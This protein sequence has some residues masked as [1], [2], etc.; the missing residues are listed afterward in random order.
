MKRISLFLILIPSILN[1]MNAASN[2]TQPDPVEMGITITMDNDN[3]KAHI[4]VRPLKDIG[5]S[6]DLSSVTHDR[7]WVTYDG[8]KLTITQIIPNPNGQTDQLMVLFSLK[9]HQ[10]EPEYSGCAMGKYGTCVPLGN[11]QHD[12]QYVLGF[13]DA[14]NNDSDT[15]LTEDRELDAKS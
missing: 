13:E 15:F 7:N 11:E 9:P 4:A 6:R 3:K 2:S 14:N 10:N 1:A 5:S 12:V 8:T